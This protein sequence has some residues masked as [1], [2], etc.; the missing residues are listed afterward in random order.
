MG[1]IKRENQV[2]ITKE[3]GLLD[4]TESRRDCDFC[5][6]DPC[7]YNRAEILVMFGLYFG[8]NDDL[9]NSFWI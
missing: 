8:R 4:L 5:L 3:N 7:L 1:T 2:I 9:I 6:Y